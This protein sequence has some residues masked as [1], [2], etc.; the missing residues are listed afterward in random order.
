MRLMIDLRTGEPVIDPL[1]NLRVINIDRLLY[2][3]LDVLFH[4]PIFEEQLLPTW[5]LDIKT[6][7]EA[8][9]NPNWEPMIRYLFVDALSPRKEPL[10]DSVE[11]VELSKDNTDLSLSAT[12]VV[13]SK[14][15]TTT[16]NVVNIYE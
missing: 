4:T 14:Y 6:I 16:K 11:S 12:I 13:K 5:G 1:G 8:S 3:Y 7:F 15:G 9:A 10:V 2:Q